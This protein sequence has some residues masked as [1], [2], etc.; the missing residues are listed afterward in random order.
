MIIRQAGKED[1]RQ[2]PEIIA[3]GRKTA[4]RGSWTEIFRA[5]RGGRTL[6]D[7]IYAA[8]ASTR[9]RR[10]GERRKGT[11]GR[12]GREYPMVSCLCRPEAPPDPP[13]PLSLPPAGVTA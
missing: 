3:E 4:R 6:A 10:G 7:G 1:V 2:I 12:G 8:A 9:P 13:G 5:P 11:H